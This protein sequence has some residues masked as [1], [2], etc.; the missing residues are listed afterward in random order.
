MTYITVIIKAVISVHLLD[1]QRNRDNPPF[2]W[3]FKSESF[4]IFPKH[5]GEHLLFFEMTQ[6][7]KIDSKGPRLFFFFK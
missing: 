6:I 5:K 4:I 2:F 7:S 1:I 3:I